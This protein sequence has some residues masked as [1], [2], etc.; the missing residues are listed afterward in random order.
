MLFGIIIKKGK[1]EPAAGKTPNLVLSD[2]ACA[3][4]YDDKEH[5]IF[6]WVG[7]NADIKSRFLASRLATIIRNRKFGGAASIIQNNDVIKA[8][9]GGT[10]VI[11][12]DIPPKY[13]AGIR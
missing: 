8:E 13:L 10:K 9:L 4:I 5:K 6:L 3:V 7:E 1:T 12:H 2:D 11:A